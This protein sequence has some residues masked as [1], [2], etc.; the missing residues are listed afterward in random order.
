VTEPFLPEGLPV[1]ELSDDDHIALPLDGPAVRRLQTA[2]GQLARRSRYVLTVR[3]GLGVDVV[4]LRQAAAP[5]TVH[6]ERIR[7]LQNQVLD[8]LAG[9]AANDDQEVDPAL[10]ASVVET[11]RALTA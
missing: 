1:A 5:L 10:R 11:F 8:A 2:Y 9:A 3:L 7:Q 6:L 4:P